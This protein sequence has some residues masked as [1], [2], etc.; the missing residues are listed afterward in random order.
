MERVQHDLR[1]DILQKN[2]ENYIYVHTSF[3]TKTRSSSPEHFRLFMYLS[4]DGY[5]TRSWEWHA[6][7]LAKIPDLENELWPEGPYEKLCSKGVGFGSS[8]ASSCADAVSVVDCLSKCEE[9]DSCAGFG[10]SGSTCCFFSSIGEMKFAPGE[11]NCFKKAS[12]EP[13]SVVG[14]LSLKFLATSIAAIGV[15]YVVYLISQGGLSSKTLAEKFA[16]KLAPFASP[17]RMGI[18]VPVADA[19]TPGPL[20]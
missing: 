15:G 10:S 19:T 18:D 7:W 2:I 16:E 3:F 9:L 17:S 6:D 13:A 8:A 4:G 5:S 14:W 20:E 11:A 1:Y 12:Y